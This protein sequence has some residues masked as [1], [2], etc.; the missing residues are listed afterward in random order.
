M[1]RRLISDGIKS[2]AE[3]HPQKPAVVGTDGNG[4]DYSD[5]VRIMQAAE[6]FIEEIN[7]RSD[8]RVAILSEDSIGGSLLTLPFAEHAVIVPLDPELGE[9]RLSFFV[10]LLRV[11]YILTDKKSGVAYKVAEE[12]GLGIL[13]FQYSGG[14]GNLQCVFQLLCSPSESML[15]AENSAEDVCLLKTTSGTTSTPKI[16]PKTYRMLCRIMLNHIKEYRQDDQDV[17]P[18]LTK[19]HQNHSF[20]NVWLTL[21]TGGTAI[22]TNGFHHK[23]FID[24]I[25]NGGVTWIV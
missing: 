23:E 25:K 4:A 24:L 11:N 13:L 10:K 12:N 6:K 17:H 8:D 1:Q 20:G 15:R 18:V 9:E 3:K 7:L 14:M 16:V 5:F 22:V 2:Q 21:Y 19:I